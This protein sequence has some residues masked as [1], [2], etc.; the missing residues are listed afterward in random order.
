[1]KKGAM[2][3]KDKTGYLT[4]EGVRQ[5][6]ALEKKSKKSIKKILKKLA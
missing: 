4:R 6:A 2:V 1:M 3:V 5:L